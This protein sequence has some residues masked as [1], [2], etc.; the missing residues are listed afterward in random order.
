VRNPA[1]T[2]D[3]IRPASRSL[4]VVAALVLVGLLLLTFANKASPYALVLGIDLLIAIL[5]AT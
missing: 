3:P 4:Q 2:D 1:E 5:F